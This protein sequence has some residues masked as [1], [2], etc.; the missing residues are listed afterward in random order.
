LFLRAVIGGSVVFPSVLRAQVG[1]GSGRPPQV[2]GDSIRIPDSLPIRDSVII[3]GSRRRN[4]KKEDPLELIK[5][6]ALKEGSTI[7]VVAPASGVAQG[8]A[9]D[10]AATLRNLGFK[11]KLGEHLTKGF[12]YLA[13]TDEERAEEF[14]KFVLDPEVNCIMA[15]R[16]GY[17]VMR[18]LPMIDFAEIRANPKI[19]IGYSDITGL[20]NP[21]YQKSGMIA[22]HGPMATS[23]FNSYTLDSFRRTLMQ[24]SPAG[25]FTE[26]EEF[27]GTIFSEARASTIVSGK[28]QGRLVGGNLTLVT[29]LMGTPWE[30]DTKG[31]I[32]FLEEV[33]EEPYRVDRMLTQLAISGKLGAC[34][35]VGLGR[36]SKCEAPSRGGEFRISLS[37]EQIVRGIVEPLNIPTI[38]GLSIGHITSKLTIPVGGLAT[39]DADA[40]TITIDEAV[41]V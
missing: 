18:I 12:G 7:A 38:Y 8:E 39:I 27:N 37:I 40:K 9:L 23:T 16:G 29:G 26:S 15:V 5:P 10:A 33:H 4:P 35:G 30:I 34:A 14:R 19:I 3:P 2:P 11:V 24:A 13:A 6:P 31:K 25:T 41:V 17:G 21:I 36:F 28:A 1:P 20:V 22:Y 32:L